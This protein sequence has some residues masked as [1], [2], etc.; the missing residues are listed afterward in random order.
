MRKMLL[1]VAVSFIAVSNIAAQEIIWS[2][3]YGGPGNEIARSICSTRSDGL[4]MAGST[5]SYGDGISD[6]YILGIAENGDTLWT[7]YFGGGLIDEA[8]G[9]IQ[10]PGESFIVAGSSFNHYSP[11]S[12]IYLIRINITGNPVWARLYGPQGDDRGAGVNSLSI[13]DSP[14]GNYLVTGNKF[15]TGPWYAE[16]FMVE[17]NA[18]GD[19]LWNR[20][21]S[22]S[23]FGAAFCSSFKAD[24]T[25][26][27]HAGFNSRTRAYLMKTQANGDSIWAYELQVGDRSMASSVKLTSDN[28]Y[29][30][31]GTARPLDSE[32]TDAFLAKFDNQGALIWINY[33]GGNEADSGFCV[34]QTSDQGYLM[35]GSTCSY[36]AGGS[37]LYLLKVDSQGDSVW[38]MTYGDANN[39]GGYVIIPAE[40]NRYLIAGYTGYS[41]STFSDCWLL[42]IAV[43]PT[44]VPENQENIVPSEY[45]LA[46]NYPNPFNSSTAIQYNLSEPARVRLEIYDILGKKIKTLADSYQPS[47]R[48]SVLWQADDYSSGI[49]FY[50]LTT[51]DRTETGRMLLLR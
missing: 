28:N 31:A 48:H 45:H 41:D 4:I 16:P 12:K 5:E 23:M 39:D 18:A 7:R 24:G 26:A 38:S 29:I 21:Y 14:D 51:A 2:R 1:V 32:T 27:V 44:G 42:K 36:G 49:Y 50:R 43:E 3:T 8:F 15:V 11:Y 9:V 17:I 33:Y 6:I 10:G 20:T 30:V 35:V 37:D 40:E 13:I 19:T 25:N 47:G 22:G 34:I 46:G